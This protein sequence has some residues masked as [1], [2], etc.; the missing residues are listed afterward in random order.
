MKKKHTKLLTGNLVLS[1]S[2]RDSKLR[3]NLLPAVTPTHGLITNDDV[4][5]SFSVRSQNT[6]RQLQ[7]Q[8]TVLAKERDEAV[9]SARA[10][11]KQQQDLYNNFKLVREKYDDLKTE[12]HQVLWE[13]IPTQQVDE[14]RGFSALGQVNYAIYETSDRIGSYIIGALLGEGQ[15]SDV[16]IC[17]HCESESRYA[18]KIIQKQKIST[19]Y[20]LKRVRNEIGLLRQLHHPNIITFVDYIHS[21]TCLYLMTEIGGADLFDFFEANPYGA[22]ESTAKQ[23]ILGI[24]LPLNYLHSSG[25]CHLDLKP[26]NILLC[27]HE[28][29]CI[30]YRD[31]RICDFGQSVIVPTNEG[32]KLTGLCGSPGFFAPEMVTGTDSTYDGF[33][34]DVWSLGCVMLELIMGHDDFC[35]FWMTSY[36]YDILQDEIEFE[37]VLG[38]A[39]MNLGKRKELKIKEDMS[40]FLMQLLV[41]DPVLRLSISKILVNKW[42]QEVAKVTELSNEDQNKKNQDEVSICVQNAS[43]VVQSESTASRGKRTFFRNS[44]SSRA[45]KH[46]AGVNERGDK[47]VLNEDPSFDIGI[48]SSNNSSEPIEIKLPP[49]EPKTPSCKVARKTVMEGEKIIQ[50]IEA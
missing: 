6:V 15:F 24:V 26:E 22:D 36:D 13:F 18:I 7:H 43:R 37:K 28:G 49:I 16:K 20:G 2:T 50:T 48:S 8:N 9:E 29:Q 32:L 34:A 44:F 39:V 27:V 46:F 5:F 25:I 42:L 10:I 23:I 14:L 41:I 38:R 35:R 4:A 1:S 30:S 3:R 12:L 47:V 17:T 33:A 45:R 31:I 11:Y 40:N 21:P 19:L